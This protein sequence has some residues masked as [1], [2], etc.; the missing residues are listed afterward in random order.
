MWSVNVAISGHTALH[1]YISKMLSLNIFFFVIRIH[2][3]L[4]KYNAQQILDDSSSVISKYT[5]KYIWLR[6]GLEARKLEFIL[7][8]KIK[9]ND[10]L[11]ADTSASSQS[12]R[13]IFSLRMSSSFITSRPGPSAWT[14]KEGFKNFYWPFQGGISFVDLLCFS[15]LWLHI[16]LFA[17]LFIC[18]LWSPAGKGLTSWLPF[19]VYNCAFAAF[20]LVSWVRCGICLTYFLPFS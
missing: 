5:L 1:Y 14:V 20:P 4:L 7:K 17:R 3:C 16:C 13:F 19:V 12:L 18:A 2:S 8:L 11:L 6:P 10:W 9:R 15:V